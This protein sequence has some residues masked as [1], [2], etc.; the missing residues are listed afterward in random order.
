MSKRLL[1]A[2]NELLK[3]LVRG[4]S[5]SGAAPPTD[6]NLAQE[7]TLQTVA[8][9]TTL[10]TVSNT[11][12]SLLAENKLDFELRSVVDDN[13]DVFQLRGT[14]DE[15]T[16]VYSWDYIDAAGAVAVPVAPVEFINPE[17]L[18]TVI[19]SE[20]QTLNATDFA[21]A[22]SQALALAELQTLNAKDF[23]T[24]TTLAL[25]V[26]AVETPGFVQSLAN[27]TVEE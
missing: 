5:S 12:T 26:P 8:T 24:E 15:E 20:L 4:Q 7:A 6:P 25:L 9:E 13:G 10:Q 27:G 1:E 16:G 21:T 11:L 23:A 2:N 18:L 17:G 14:L 22:A 19:Y 3:C